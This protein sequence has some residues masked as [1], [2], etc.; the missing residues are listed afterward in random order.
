M[1]KYITCSLEDNERYFACIVRTY[2][3][4]TDIFWPPSH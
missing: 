3:E 1:G 4:D 2:N